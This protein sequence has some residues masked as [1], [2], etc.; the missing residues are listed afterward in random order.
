MLILSSFFHSVRVRATTC[1]S[2]FTPVEAEKY[3][4]ASQYTTVWQHTLVCSEE[5]MASISIP[6]KTD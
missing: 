6:D 3:Q 2:W 5:I 4:A 1:Y